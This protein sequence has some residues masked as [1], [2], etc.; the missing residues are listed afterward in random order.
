MILPEPAL[1][2]L[3]RAGWQGA[4]ARPLAGDASGRSYARLTLGERIA[5]LMMSPSPDEV[6][7]F[8]NVGRW[9]LSNGFSAPAIMASDAPAGLMLIEDLGD[10]LIFGLVGADPSLEAPLYRAI[11]ETL[12]A[13][14]RLA[15][16][17]FVQPLDAAG[18]GDLTRLG[19]DWAPL[20]SMEA[21]AAVPGIVTALAARLDDLAPV[22]CLRDFHAQ[23]MLW[24]PGREGIARLGLLDFQDAVAAHPGYD[25]VSALQDVRRAVS[26]SVEAREI[27]RYTAAR[28]L[29]PEAFAADYALLGAQRAL[30]IH[31]VFARLCLGAGKARYV[32]L[33]PRNWALL[34]R[35]LAHPA[36]APLA[37]AVGAAY[38]PPDD[39]LLERLKRECGTRPMR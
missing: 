21:A 38:A 18:L 39:A 36:L 19:Q 30:R 2:F 37:R 29:D 23:N 35:N 3:A 11:T 9:L 13:L 20:L 10:D 28:G 6:T 1:T 27:A 17:G 32:D 5:V 33:M 4:L 8:E 31:A 22:L 25:L 24:L 34:H 16:P 12:L 26:P 14:H 15:P 7:R